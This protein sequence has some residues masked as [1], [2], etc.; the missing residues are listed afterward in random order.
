MSRQ[1]GGFLLRVNDTPNAPLSIARFCDRQAGRPQCSDRE[2]GG[3]DAGMCGH[4]PPSLPA[5]ATI[6]APDEAANA[7]AADRA[8]CAEM[9]P[10]L[11]LTEE[12]Q[13]ASR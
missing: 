3:M 2:N 7:T 13:Y 12:S 11:P 10:P 6:T 4:S 5:A 1:L 9:G 8:D